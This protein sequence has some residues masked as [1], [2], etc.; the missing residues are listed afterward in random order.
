MQVLAF[1]S[2]L[3]GAASTMDISWALEL[4]LLL[5]KCPAQPLPT[6]P[7]SS[8]LANTLPSP[9]LLSSE[10]GSLP[11]L[12]FSKPISPL[13]SPQTPS[14]SPPRAR[15]PKCPPSIPPDISFQ[16]QWPQLKSLIL[17]GFLRP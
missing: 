14:A 2:V 4:F 5:G 12:D 1:S 7:L 17:T 10:Q 11:L 16:G 9:P 13:P 15:L 6:S 8:T 3:S